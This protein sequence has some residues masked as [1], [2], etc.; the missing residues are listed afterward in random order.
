LRHK[1]S[2]IVP[3]IADV[4]AAIPSLTGKFELEY[5]GELRGAEAIAGELIRS[6]VGKVFD[7]YFADADLLAIVQWFDLGGQLKVASDGASRE[8][9]G[10]LK[11]IQGLLDK[12]APLGVK[13]KDDP[14]V[15]VS[16]A[17]FVLEGLYAHRRIN[18]SEERGYFAEEKKRVEPR[19][20]LP[21]QRRS[22]N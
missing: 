20:E 2:V 9:L 21:R 1:E 18:R 7:R 11:Q 17:E 5:E 4:Y 22:Y 6:A 16:A 14:A 8:L 15:V 19:E 10:Q 13:A 3:R 12:I